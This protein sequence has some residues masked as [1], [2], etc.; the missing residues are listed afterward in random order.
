MITVLRKAIKGK[1]AKTLLI[2][3]AAAV[4]GLFSLPLLFDSTSSGPWIAKV[5]GRPVSYNDFVRKS[6]D[7]ENRIR[8]FRAQYGQ[9][10]D[11]LMQSMGMQLDP[12]L[13]A[14]N[15]L[16][17]EELVDQLAKKLNLY[18]DD[19]YMSEMLFNSTFLFQELSDLVPPSLIDPQAGLNINGL[20]NYLS[21][22]GLSMS[23]FE[24]K[25]EEKLRRS[26]AVNLMLGSAYV[27]DSVVRDRYI[28]EY[29]PRRFSVML[30][31]FN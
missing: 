25:V 20:R 15:Q 3:I 18:L 4:G 30:F 23:D 24:Q 8:Q 21:R 27:P 13:L 6:M 11:M 2:I 5:N 12:K 22:Q 7:N 10:A 9:L 29:S 14:A 28:Q 1:A 16:I 19:D 31:V 17:R 26:F